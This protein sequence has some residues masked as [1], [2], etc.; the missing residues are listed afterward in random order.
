MQESLVG[1]GLMHQYVQLSNKASIYEYPIDP[2]AYMC[3]RIPFLMN[4][5]F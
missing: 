4:E 2:D 5:A 1:F 3:S